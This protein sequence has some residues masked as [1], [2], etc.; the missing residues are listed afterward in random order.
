GLVASA[1]LSRRCD[2]AM[3]DTWRQYQSAARRGPSRGAMVALDVSSRSPAIASA[4]S[5]DKKDRRNACANRC[6][7]DVIGAQLLAVRRRVAMPLAMRRA[8][9]YARAMARSPAGWTVYSRLRL[10]PRSGV[11]SPRREATNPR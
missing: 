3:L 9:S 4:A 5:A 8:D 10:P 2:Q 6:S 7:L 1:T 11:G